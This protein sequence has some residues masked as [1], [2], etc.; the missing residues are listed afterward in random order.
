MKDF[1]IMRFLRFF[2]TLPFDDKVLGP[3]M[4]FIFVAFVAGVWRSEFFGEVGTRDA[5]TV[6]AAGIDDHVG[7]LRH[8]A[9]NATCT[10]GVGIVEMMRAGSKYLIKMTP[11]TQTITLG[12]DLHAVRFMTVKADDTFVE[13]FALQK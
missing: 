2:L 10:C 8:M 11:V 3:L 4:R 12:I 7:S 6:I 9:L 5:Y 13:H 1:A